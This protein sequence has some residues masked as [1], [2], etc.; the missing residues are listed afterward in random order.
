MKQ[1]LICFLMLSTL[2]CSC[3]KNELM[4]YTSMDNLY[5]KYLDK[6]GRQDTTTISYSFAYNP[7]LAKDTLWI[8]VIVTG[9][10]LAQS[11]Q[12]VL[13]VV[14]SLTTALKDIHYEPLKPTYILPADSAT[15][16]I[17]LILKNTDE[18][19][20]NRSVS[21]GIR[22]VAG[23]Q[24]QADLPLALRTKKFIFSSRL[25]RPAWWNFWQS[26][27]GEY[28]R[29]KHQLFLI[30]TGTIDLVDLSKPNAY[31][32][33][34]R[35]LYHIDNF[36]VFLKDPANWIARNPAKGYVLVKKSTVDEFE[37]YAAS[38]PTKRFALKY[39]ALVNNYF[40][41]DENGK[42]III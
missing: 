38:A 3:K 8:P 12:F 42:Q 7:G 34:P 32:E 30:A 18:T 23:G 20:A 25:E 22:A 2:F 13:Q 16:R 21:I 24:F 35:T 29:I 27:L 4:P 6:D 9:P 15:L 17:P 39:F 1:K 41:I 33:I 19:L 26:Q 31:L 28:G 37:F 36:R 11:R 14:D 5:L 40:F 10:R